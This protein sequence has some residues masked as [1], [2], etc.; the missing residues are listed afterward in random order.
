MNFFVA[1]CD[2]DYQL[3]VTVEY[4]NNFDPLWSSEPENVFTRISFIFDI[5]KQPNELEQ[6]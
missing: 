6:Q 2:G 1:V 4:W 3:E 5:C